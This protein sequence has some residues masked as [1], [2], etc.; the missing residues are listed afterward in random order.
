MAKQ[1][2]PTSQQK[3]NVADEKKQQPIAENTSLTAKESV[4]FKYLFIGVAVLIFLVR[5]FYSSHF[6]PSSDEIYHK[7]IGDLSYD[8]L[9]TFGK[10]DSIFRY[11]GN[12][13]EDAAL[14]MN[15]GP[16]L[17]VTAAAIYK[18]FGTDPFPTRHA[19]LTVFT[20]ILFLFCGLAAKKIGGWRAALIAMLFM[21]L[22]PRLLGESFNNPKDPTFAAGYMMGVCML[23]YFIAELP[24]PSWKS[25]LLL[26]VGAGFA[27]SVR[28]GGLLVF[29]YTFM[30]VGLAL[31][32]KEEWR[33]HLLTFDFKYYKDLLLKLSV[34][35]IGGWII[36]IITWPSAI[37]SPIFHPIHAYQVQSSYPT[38]IRVLFG[39]QY[40]PSNEV[41]WSYNP[42]YIYLTTPAIILLGMLLGTLLLPKMRKYFNLYFIG[43]MLFVSLFP[44]AFI[45]I[46]KS[47]LLNGWRHSYFTYTGLAVFAAIGFEALFRTIQSKV[48][49]YVLYAILAVGML[50]PALF[51]A[52]NFPVVY[53]YFN[54]LAGGVDGTYGDYQMDYYAC[55]AKPA[56]DWMTKNIPSN[57]TEKIVSNNPWELN[58]CWESGKSTRK[59]EYI[60]FRERNEQNWDYAVF[61]PQFVDPKMMKRHFFPPKGTIHEVKVDNSVIACVVKRENKSDFYGIEAVKK[62][63]FVNGIKFLED[64][65]KFDGYNEIAWTYLGIAYANTGRMQ[66]ASTALTN[67]INIS[68]EYQLPQYYYQQ[69]AGQGR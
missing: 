7:T 9:S 53:V 11:T 34:V 51:I 64:A 40:I 26:M 56:A 39:G 69:I 10:N 3:I 38:V 21:L 59:S 45:I 33:K 46:K 27:F 14:L 4:I 18:N 17:E 29:I 35:L 47:A 1:S 57:E 37:L 28:V 54:E 68:P 42:T 61:L 63:D 41:P 66:E 25:T 24:R 58:M 6:G 31:L 19:V 49:Q 67:A 50:S 62:N 52:K 5:P 36:G 43:I 30:F 32:Q 60:R 13:R 65:V 48:G 12:G 8:Y 23:L 2:K 22:S 15:Y 16:L 55:S 44:I 20:F